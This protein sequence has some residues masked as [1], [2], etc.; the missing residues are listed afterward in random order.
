MLKIFHRLRRLDSTLTGANLKGALNLTI[1]KLSKV[2]TL[3]HAK[4]Y[5][6]I[7][8]PLKKNYPALFEEPK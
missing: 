5:K 6:K 1:D 8:N 4:L 3:Y 2:E 7:L